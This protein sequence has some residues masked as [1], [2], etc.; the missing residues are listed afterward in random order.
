[1]KKEQQIE[2]EWEDLG[3]RGARTDFVRLLEQAIESKFRGKA[4]LRIPSINALH[5]TCTSERRSLNFDLKWC[6]DLILDEP[7]DPFLETDL[8]SARATRLAIAAAVKSA[9]KK[10]RKALGE[11]SDLARGYT[12]LHLHFK[13]NRLAVFR[14]K[15]EIV[16]KPEPG[17][18]GRR[19]R[20][21]PWILRLFFLIHGS[22][23]F[24]GG[25][26]PR[27]PKM[28]SGTIAVMLK[29]LADLQPYYPEISNLKMSDGKSILDEKSIAGRIRDNAAT[30]IGDYKK[31]EFE[32]LKKSAKDV[33]KEESIELVVLENR[34]MRGIDL[35]LARMGHKNRLPLKRKKT[36]S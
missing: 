27:P 9:E 30:Y 29:F 24:F 35:Y 10:I 17:K 18:G 3:I 20:D 12:G 21:T 22:Y 13:S 1:M 25:N 28:V 5:D 8:A 16:W 6:I 34:E 33:L 7:Q 4:R 15:E 23:E 26:A 11:K 31:D 14:G 36:R 19:D 32:D 2:E